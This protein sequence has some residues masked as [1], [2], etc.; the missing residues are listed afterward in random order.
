M[1]MART[2]LALVILVLSI[3]YGAKF[4]GKLIPYWDESSEAT[5]PVEVGIIDTNTILIWRVT[6]GIH[7]VF[8]CDESYTIVDDTES[9]YYFI[10]GSPV[11]AKNGSFPTIERRFKTPGDYY[12][13]DKS[14]PN[15]R[16]NVTVIQAAHEITDNED[17]EDSHSRGMQIF[18]T[19]L[20]WIVFFLLVIS[21]VGAALVII[22]FTAFSDIRTF[23]IK[24]ILYL[25]WCIVIGN[26][27]FLFAFE[28]AF[29]DNEY[30]CYTL[31]MVVHGFFLANFCWTFCI[32]FNFYQMIVR[33]NRESN[34]LEKWYHLFSWGFPLACVMWTSTFLEY[35]DRGGV[36]YITSPV[37]V[38]LF[39]FMPG[40]IIISSNAILFFFVIREIHET[41]STSPKTDKSEKKRELRVYLSIFITI[42]LSWIFGFLMVLF[43]SLII[44][45]IFLVLFS[46]TTPLQGFLLFVFYC[47]NARVFGKWIGVF[48]R[49]FPFLKRYEDLQVS[50]SATSSGRSTSS[51]HSLVHADTSFR[52]SSLSARSNLWDSDDDEEYCLLDLEGFMEEDAQYLDSSSSSS[53]LSSHYSATGDPFLERDEQVGFDFGS[54]SSSSS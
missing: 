8:P 43:Q 13:R 14:Y 18:N 35:G 49:C 53:Y 39:F 54:S 7:G 4:P 6:E 36:C 15:I 23:P 17:D 48:T 34:E 51:R 33:R 26:T 41:L 29:T 46:I 21:I 5:F 25:C 52:S 37:F 38:F 31:G 50:R 47:V 32:S 30:V 27:A 20:S 12:F 45:L 2:R 40:L 42:G 9:P 28:G 16:G 10:P 3:V 1:R 11:V 22:T 24:L 19:V 44:R